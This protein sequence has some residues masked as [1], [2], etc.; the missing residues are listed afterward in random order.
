MYK[1]ISV[2]IPCYK[3]RNHIISVLSNIGPEVNRIYVIDDCCP[4]L[5][6]DFVR[7]NYNDPDR[8]SVV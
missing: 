7:K 6:G 3:V 5:S 8:K 2:V 4:E 1:N